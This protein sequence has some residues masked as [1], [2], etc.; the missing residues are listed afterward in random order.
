MLVDMIDRG[1]GLKRACGRA[2]EG[3]FAVSDLALVQGEG[4]VTEDHEATAVELAAFVFMEIEDHFFVGEF[5]L[6]YFHLM[7]GLA[8]HCRNCDL[9]VA[10]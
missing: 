9:H 6:G 10:A 7:L 5:I 8:Y 1:Q 4:A 2:G 3:K